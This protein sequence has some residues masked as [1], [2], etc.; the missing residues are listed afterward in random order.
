MV[1]GGSSDPGARA[2]QRDLW[3]LTP[4]LRALVRVGRSHENE[5]RA[6]WER[7][8]REP[9]PFAN[10]AVDLLREVELL[11]ARASKEPS[12]V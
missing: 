7:A 8:L 2:T 3:E 10:P 4:L 5:L 1:A 6:E 9:M 12:D 11:R